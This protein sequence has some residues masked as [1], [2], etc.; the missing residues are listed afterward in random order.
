MG[1]GNVA[2]ICG[3]LLAAGMPPKLP[4]A[5]IEKGTTPEQRTVTSTLAA[6]PDAIEEADLGT[7]T[8][9]IIGRVVA[10][11]EVLGR[12]LAPEDDGVAALR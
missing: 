5:A 6:L 10:L 1:L 11:A 3:D 7:P 9:V 12:H 4:A 2:R 8:L